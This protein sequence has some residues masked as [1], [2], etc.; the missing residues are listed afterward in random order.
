MQE[1]LLVF[2]DQ[3]GRIV[4]GRKVGET[5]TSISVLN[6]VIIEQEAQAGGQLSVHTFPYVCIEFTEGG[7]QTLVWE[8]QK[9][10]IAISQI[11]LEPRLRDL[12]L[13]I[14]QPKQPVAPTQNAKI[15]NLFD[16]E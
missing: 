7:E 4:A 13:K 11:E 8:F 12:C 1:K 15:V 16:G 10:S 14:N 9:S 2:S 6:P 5:D 3:I